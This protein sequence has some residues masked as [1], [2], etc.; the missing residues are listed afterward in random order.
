MNYF[1]LLGPFLFLPLLPFVAVSALM[2]EETN[3][4]PS[5]VL[6]MFPRIETPML[7]RRL[8]YVAANR[9]PIQPSLASLANSIPDLVRSRRYERLESRLEIGESLGKVLLDEHFI[10]GREAQSIDNATQIGHLGWALTSLA[11]TI[12]QRRLDRARWLMEFVRPSVILMLA[13]V[14]GSFCLS[15][16]MPLVK[17]IVELS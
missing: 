11:N 17:L 4:I 15:M 9:Y 5:F 1:Y 10:N 7:L 14:V 12:Q 6:R 13:V 3:W 16:F 8:G 2:V